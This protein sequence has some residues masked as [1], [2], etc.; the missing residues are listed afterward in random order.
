MFSANCKISIYLAYVMTIYSI[1]SLVYMMITLGS[2]ARPFYNS[3]TRRQ[4]NI[5]KGVKKKRRNIFILGCVIGIG[6]L[7]YLKPF[8]Q[9]QQNNQYPSIYSAP[10]QVP[11]VINQPVPVSNPNSNITGGRHHTMYNS[12]GNLMHFDP[13]RTVRTVSRQMQ[14]QNY[15]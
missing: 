9:C 5:L 14:N 13:L 12:G 1:A 15:R 3:L 7:F 10:S 11:V 8:T 4:K 6:V 2:K